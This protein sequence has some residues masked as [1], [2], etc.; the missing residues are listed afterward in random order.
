MVHII[1]NSYFGILSVSWRDSRLFCLYIKLNI[2]NNEHL[3]K[4]LSKYKK[5]VRE[6]NYSKCLVSINYFHQAKYVIGVY[7][8]PSR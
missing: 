7:P 5:K 6:S 3:I 4:S 8:I 2:I 1:C